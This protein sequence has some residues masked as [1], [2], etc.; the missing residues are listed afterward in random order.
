MDY[1][2]TQSNS[3]V[4]IAT[5]AGENKFS[6]YGDQPVK[7]FTARERDIIKLI[8][9]QYTNREMAMLLNLSIRTIESHREKI[10]EKVGS[11]NSIGIVIYAIKYQIY[12]I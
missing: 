4:E 12:E 1:V 5:L 2:N 7:K 9:K 8:C 11:R 6:P 10:Q 3:L